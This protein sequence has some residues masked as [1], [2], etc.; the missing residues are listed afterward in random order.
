MMMTTDEFHVYLHSTASTDLYPSNVGGKF[1]NT[2][3]KPILLEGDDWQVGISSIICKAARVSQLTS[4]NENVVLRT[5]DAE[6]DDSH[7]IF[8]WKSYK[9]ISNLLGNIIST[10]LGGTSDNFK[11][12]LLVTYVFYD[13]IYDTKDNSIGFVINS[14]Y[15]SSSSRTDTF[16]LYFLNS[17]NAYQCH[18]ID[19]VVKECNRNIANIMHE[20]VGGKFY[21]PVIN[22]QKI[23]LSTGQNIVKPAKKKKHEVFVPLKFS[24][25][26]IECKPVPMPSFNAT[27]N[28]WSKV[29]TPILS[30]VA[31]IRCCSKAN[32]Y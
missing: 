23:V 6:N 19:D 13:E 7:K 31:N 18:T 16:T 30:C 27:T 24:K 17:Q 20:D 10:N 29:T 5:F 3:Q 9:E 12:N 11:I 15:E 25:D 2:P 8:G 1:N 4:E 14:Q 32:G 26:K 22:A 28:Y 21:Y